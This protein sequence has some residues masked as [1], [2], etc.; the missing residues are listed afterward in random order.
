MATGDS[1][2]GLV[3]NDAEKQIVQ[4]ALSMKVASITR[5]M[6][7]QVSTS[8]IYTALAQDRKSVVDLSSKF[9]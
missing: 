5:A 3:L 4:N 1:K 8:A 9:I 2:T 7:A 6:S